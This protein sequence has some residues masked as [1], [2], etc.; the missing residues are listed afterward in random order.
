MASPFELIRRGQAPRSPDALA[1]RPVPRRLH[2]LAA[3]A[4]SFQIDDDLAEAVNVALAVG[5][6]LLL[7]G[8]PGTGKTQLAY[9]LAWQF[10]LLPEQPFTFEVKS[11]SAARDLLYRFDTVAYFHEAQRRDGVAIDKQRFVD[12]GP[13]WLAFEAIAAGRPAIVLIDEIDKAPRDFP[14]DLLHELDQF[15]FTVTETGQK[16][17]ADRLAAPPVVVVTSNS[18]KRLP[19]AFLRRCIFHRIA[20]SEAILREAVDARRELM[21][22]QD[23][24][25]AA[26]RRFLELRRKLVDN[27]HRPPA[28]GEFLV[29]LAALQAREVGADALAP[30]VPLARLPLLAAL[31]KDAQARES[32]G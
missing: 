26:Q 16:I 5:A 9:F 29:W 18:E 15:S 11:S 28:T 4:E 17:T 23:V 2:D 13:L 7:T 22:R 6:P 31:V 30:E 21:R 1:G 25:D 27:Q 32:L 19:E 3:A 12:K 14:N 20:F 8:E 24:S 10:G